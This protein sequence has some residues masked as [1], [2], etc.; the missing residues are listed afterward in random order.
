MTDKWDENSIFNNSLFTPLGSYFWKEHNKQNIREM[1]NKKNKEQKKENIEL[2][3][4]N[5]ELKKKLELLR[6]K[7]N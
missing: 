7:I 5:E 6:K 1:K 4:E 3:K 2:K